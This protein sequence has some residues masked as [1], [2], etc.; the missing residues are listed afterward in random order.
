MRSAA[1]DKLWEGFNDIADGF[2]LTQSEF[3]EV[4]RCLCTR[5]HEQYGLAYLGR[6]ESNTETCL[7][8]MLAACARMVV[9]CVYVPVL[10][11]VCE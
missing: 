9:V 7:L 10:P 4:S 3:V 2:G 1:L 5:G 6:Q 8:A 11:K